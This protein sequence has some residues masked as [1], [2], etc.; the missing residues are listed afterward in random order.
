MSLKQRMISGGMQ[1]GLSQLISMGLSFG[2][3]IVIGR[4]L[5]IEDM[6]IASTIALALQVIES[7]SDINVNQLMIQSKDGDDPQL[8]ANAHTYTL[9]RGVI[10][11]AVLLLLGGPLARLFG[12]PDAAWAFQLMALAPLIRGVWHQDLWRYHRAMRFGPLV[13]VEILSQVLALLAS[14]PLAIWLN[15]Y[16]VMLWVILIQAS[17]VAILSHIAN[18]RPYRLGLDRTN[19]IS[20]LKFGWPL[21]INGVLMMLLNYGDR[22]V[23]AAFPTY[24][25]TDVG[26]YMIASSVTFMP[27]M[28]LTKLGTT[29]ILPVLAREQDDA[30]RFNNRF[31][32]ITRIVGF[33]AIAQTVLLIIAGPAAVTLCFG[34]KYL[35]VAAFFGW[36]AAG[37]G[38]RV[39]K[40]APTLG[41]LAYGDSLNTLLTTVARCTGFGIAIAAASMGADLSWLAIAGLLG[42]IISL[43]VS[44]LSLAYRRS[45]FDL[46]LVTWTVL[47]LLAIAISMG[48]FQMIGGAEAGWMVVPV[49]VVAAGVM[50]SIAAVTFFDPNS[51]VVI[52]ARERLTPFFSRFQRNLIHQD[53]EKS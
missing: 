26:L 34:E 20:I 37:T 38:V 8:Q 48:I 7:A 15:N 52:K 25:M 44:M 11:A 24:T 53:V 12:V 22:F 28:L 33:V 18:E 14:W 30:E 51:P 2:R 23:I 5:S 41:A 17:V 1:V 42:E 32:M 3:N 10:T 4:I 6:G 50:A 9:L 40:L 27:I 49:T 46:T 45:V 35:P 36:M 47:L 16:S 29:I 13:R 39:L 19:G 43:V 31:R 21:L